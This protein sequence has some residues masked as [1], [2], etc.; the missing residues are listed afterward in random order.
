[1]KKFSILALLGVCLFTSCKK[2]FTCE[3]TRNSKF[4]NTSGTTVNDPSITTYTLKDISKGNAKAACSNSSSEYT[5][6]TPG[7]T[8]GNS[9]ETT[10]VLK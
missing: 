2:D 9:S 6:T 8:S 3:C 5:N 1:M 7:T 10:C 4:T